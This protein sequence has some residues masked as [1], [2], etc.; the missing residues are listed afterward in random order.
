MS[1]SVPKVGPNSPMPEHG[2]TSLEEGCVEAWLF[3]EL[4]RCAYA[5]P[6][7]VEGRFARQ[8]ID[9]ACKRARKEVAEFLASHLASHSEPKEGQDAKS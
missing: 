3:R 5:H 8:L 4:R 6:N 9:S 7:T 2:L 1:T